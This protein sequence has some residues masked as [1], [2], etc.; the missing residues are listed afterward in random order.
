MQS[1]P[2]AAASEPP[3]PTALAPAPE[4]GGGGIQQQPSA[5]A[6]SQAWRNTRVLAVKNLRLKK[7]QHAQC[8]CHCLPCTFMWEFLFPIGI[9]ALFAWLRTL[10]DPDTTL[11]GWW[12]K[13]SPHS[14]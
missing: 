8:S 14:D 10:G 5:M 3:V 4:G 13:R 6:P 9:I 12:V 2:E 1:T 11:T 7:K